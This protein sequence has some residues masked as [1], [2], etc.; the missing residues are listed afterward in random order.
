MLSILCKI[1]SYFNTTIDDDETFR[2]KYIDLDSELVE[3]IKS[4]ALNNLPS[5]GRHF[6]LLDIK[7]PDILGIPV[8]CTRLIYTPPLFSNSYAHKDPL[9]NSAWVVNIP[10][11]N[12][13]N[14]VTTLYESIPGKSVKTINGTTPME[15]LDISK[16][17]AIDSYV[18]NK[19][20]LLN[21]R[22]FHAINNFSD[23][24]RLVISLQ[25]KTNPIE[26]IK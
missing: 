1:K 25:F 13:E 9:R 12:C 7:M 20:V 14:S 22:I 16:T 26:W 2:W 11:V 5:N 19:P 10:L 18:L 15:I 4:I 17:K 24:Q 23:E 3:E 21:T 6:Q 8:V